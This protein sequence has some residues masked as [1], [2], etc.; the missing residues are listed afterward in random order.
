M[1]SLGSISAFDLPSVGGLST[2]DHTW[3]NDNVT[4]PIVSSTAS[5]LDT[6]QD[7]VDTNTTK[8]NTLQADVTIIK[9]NTTP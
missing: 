2:A 1:A 4:I 9:D 7:S 6:V 5:L 3:L 8:L